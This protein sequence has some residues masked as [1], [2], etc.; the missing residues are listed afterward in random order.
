MFLPLAVNSSRIIIGLSSHPLPW[1]RHWPS[2]TPPHS[3]R[4]RPDSATPQ[5]AVE[6]RGET[7]LSLP[8]T[9]NPTA[10][11]HTMTDG[12]PSKKMKHDLRENKA[13][14]MLAK[15]AEGGYGIPGVCVVSCFL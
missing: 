10:R 11:R 3:H 5:V 1:R 13:N 9:Q 6:E 2:K 8:A 12:P 4:A 7:L 15:A 14:I